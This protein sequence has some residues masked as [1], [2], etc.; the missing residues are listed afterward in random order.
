LPWLVANRDQSVSELWKHLDQRFQDV[1]QADRA[2]D[3]LR[4]LRQGKRSV[5]DYAAEF[6]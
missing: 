6:D 3:K 1:H 5:R 2:M 4:H